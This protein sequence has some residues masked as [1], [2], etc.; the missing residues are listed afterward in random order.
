MC[1]II[2]NWVQVYY[3][4][5]WKD[6]KSLKF[7]C[8]SFLLKN[9]LKAF[10]S[11]ESIPKGFFL[12]NLLR[13]VKPN[14]KFLETVHRKDP[15]LIDWIEVDPI[16][17]ILMIYLQVLIVNSWNYCHFKYFYKFYLPSRT[18]M[19][20]KDFCILNWLHIK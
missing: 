11:L 9:N 18:H 2:F 6:L 17:Q 5:T 16:L 10:R 15:H 20:L 12:C 3:C 19:I 14:S 8:C 4:I 1:S 7:C 13:L